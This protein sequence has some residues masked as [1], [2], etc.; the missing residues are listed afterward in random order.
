MT[1]RK[2]CLLNALGRE[3]ERKHDKENSENLIN[4][5]DVGE[6]MCESSHE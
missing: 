1:V 3:G 5:N 4:Q 6:N 2:L